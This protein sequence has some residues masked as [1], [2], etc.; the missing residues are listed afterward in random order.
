MSYWTHTGH[1]T[2][3]PASAN[4]ATINEVARYCRVDAAAHYDLLQTLFDAATR[5]AERETGISFLTQ[6][7]QAY[8][9]KFEKIMRLP[10]GIVQSISSIT[11]YDS[12]NELQTLESDYYDG[13]LSAFPPY[14]K[15]ADGYTWP[16]TYKRDDAVTIEYIAGFG[17]TSD[18]VPATF[19]VGVMALTLAMFDNPGAAGETV[20]RENTAISRLLNIESILGV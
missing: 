15:L 9:A 11:Y 16:E 14:L 13:Q 8:Y 17:D 12:T 10:G 4:L 1:K 3:V 7:Q 19:R 20:I 18:D 6:T 5:T 2:T